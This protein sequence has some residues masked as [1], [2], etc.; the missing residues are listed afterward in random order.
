MALTDA[1][2]REILSSAGIP[3]ENL[4]NATKKIMDGHILSIN[5]LR[6][7]RDGFK[8]DAEKLP[9]VQKEL[10]D[11]KAKGDQNWQQ[12][13]EKEHSDFDAYKKQI[14][15][16]KDLNQK[17]DLYRALLR[18]EK[19]EEKRIDSILKVTDLTSLKVVDGKLDDVE[20]LKN[21]IKTEWSG[22][23]VSE[24]IEGAEVDNPPA[25][26]EKGAFEK[27]SLGDKMTYANEHP[28]D[29]SVIDWLKK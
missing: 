11:L 18:S 12:K 3:A 20:T 13:Y 21:T 9:T 14:K 25:N 22:F 5:A 28:T 1:Q 10:D 7:Q 15:D 2:V 6:E 26:N 27:L 4:E 24:H 19:V 29:Q 16:E 23:I 8:A 17:A